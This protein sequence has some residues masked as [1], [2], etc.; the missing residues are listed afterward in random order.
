MRQLTKQIAL[1][2]RMDQLIRL[3][4]T[5]KPKQLSQKLEVSEA[6]IFRLIDI[7]KEL[8]APVFY[9]WSRQSYAYA[10]PTVFKCGFFVKGLAE[11][12]QRD[13]TGGFGFQNIKRL[14]GF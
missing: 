5:G 14:F 1:L 2:E 11:E 7:M 3:K 6:T 10:E 8:N 12:E 9:D 4:A 13:L